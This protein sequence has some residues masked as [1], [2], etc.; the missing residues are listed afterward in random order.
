MKRVTL[1]A[2]AALAVVTGTLA[3]LGVG[4]AAADAP[5][6][7]GLTK[8]VQVEQCD[9]YTPRFQVTTPWFQTQCLP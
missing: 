6:N 3:S 8:C 1:L 5:C 4:V 2:A 9:P 7:G